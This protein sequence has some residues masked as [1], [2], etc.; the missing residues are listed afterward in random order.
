M[1]IPF[2]K[3][4]FIS[5]FIKELEADAVRVI[6]KTAQPPRIRAGWI[7]PPNG[8]VK[9]NVD[10]AISTELGKSTAA[11]IFRAEDKLFLGASVL[12]IGAVLDPQLSK[13]LLVEKHST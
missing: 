13:P 5:R 3:S 12:V 9:G 10:G 4:K 1:S 11:A 8:E 7:P 2:A 6:P